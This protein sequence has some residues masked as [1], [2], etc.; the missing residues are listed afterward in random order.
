MIVIDEADLILSYGYQADVEKIAKYMPK[1]CQGFLASATL[2]EAVETLKKLILHTPVVLKLEEE[3]D[4][5]ALLKQFSILTTR[6]RE[7]FL[8]LYVLLKLGLVKGK[9]IIFVHGI[10]QCYRLKIFLERLSINAAVLNSELPQNSRYHIVQEFNKGLISILIAAADDVI[11]DK[12][13]RSRPSDNAMD[14]S[15]DENGSGSDDESGS[16]SDADDTTAEK[17]V[18]VNKDDS[19]S[20]NNEESSASDHKASSK[21]SPKKKVAFQET[22]DDEEEAP[23]SKK[24]S[25]KSGNGK[26]VSFAGKSNDSG[27]DDDGSDEIS[28]LSGSDISMESFSDMEEDGDDSDEE[29]E[30]DFSSSEE[31]EQTLAEAQTDGKDLVEQIDDSI[32][33]K[34]GKRGISERTLNSAV[35]KL[36]AIEKAKER[37]VA[38]SK[39]GSNKFDEEYGVS[40]GVDFRGVQTVINFELPFTPDAYTH[41]VGRTARAGQSGVA[42]SFYTKGQVDRLNTIIEDQKAKGLEV[43]PYTV[44]PAAVES[45]RYRL[46]DVMKTVSLFS[47]REARYEEIRREILASQKLQTFFQNNPR[48]QELLKHDRNLMRKPLFQTLKVVPDYLV[49]SETKSTLEPIADN[50][51][52][53]D[54]SMRKNR[55]GKRS[56]GDDPLRSFS[57]PPKKKHRGPPRGSNPLKTPKKGK[58]RE[59]LPGEG[60]TRRKK[61]SFKS[62]T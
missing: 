17:A 4:K 7:R 9:M 43:A 62:I 28:E 12:K 47:I 34:K 32:S 57:G 10:T 56:K 15:D 24:S 11:T 1:I 49:T 42:I 39:S 25:D 21:K 23:K 60:S 54:F 18:V 20:D 38:K 31:E 46:N 55:P 2:G 6:R 51:F 33:G 29:I 50:S 30:M 45:F 61:R 27:S 16:E 19:D 52:Q 5:R 8:Q 40:R 3:N 14:I 59:G 36:N 37:E 41:R 44:S 53:D 26:K 48:E 22:S 13:E 35:K 58:F